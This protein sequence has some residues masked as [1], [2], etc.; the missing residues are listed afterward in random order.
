LDVADKDAMKSKT[1]IFLIVLV[2]CGMAAS[3]VTR[4]IIAE[5]K[6]RM[7]I[8]DKW[9]LRKWV[10]LVRAYPEMQGLP[11]QADAA[12]S[13]ARIA[14]DEYSK[15]PRRCRAVTSRMRADDCPAGLTSAQAVFIR[16]FV[17]GGFN[18]AS[19]ETRE[20]R[21]LTWKDVLTDSIPPRDKK[22]SD[23]LNPHCL[24]RYPR[25]RMHHEALH[26]FILGSHR[27]ELERLANNHALVELIDQCWQIGYEAGCSLSNY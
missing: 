16:S 26:P 10:E 18:T 21:N 14:A 19:A 15:A 3:Y 25:E 24:D 13:W 8:S 7:T 12:L 22:P 5:R 2:A 6:A 11:S 9:L 27:V 17:S 1:L 23:C 20:R 4:L